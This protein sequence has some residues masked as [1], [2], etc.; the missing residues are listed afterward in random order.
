MHTPITPTASLPPS[1]PIHELA[2]IIAVVVGVVALHLVPPT[3]AGVSAR[4]RG[5]EIASGLV[6]LVAAAEV[7]A[8]EDL[9]AAS[10][11]LASV[12]G[13][14]VLAVLDLGRTR[15]RVGARVVAAKLAVSFTPIVAVAPGAGMLGAERA[16]AHGQLETADSLIQVPQ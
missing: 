7:A 13:T 15:V 10:A 5:L 8:L 9:L 16:G 14:V 2:A 12:R 11:R 1:R 4:G 6:A 3:P